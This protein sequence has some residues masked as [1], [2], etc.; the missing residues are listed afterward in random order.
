MFFDSHCHLQDPRIAPFLDAILDRAK[1]AGVHGFLC[2]ASEENDWPNV[3]SVAK[4][5]TA[6]VAAYGL[7]PWYVMG[8]SSQWLDKLETILVDNPAAC[9]GEIG[10]DHCLEKDTFADQES[11]FVD[12]LTLSAKLSRPVSIHCRKAFG[13]MMEILKRHF[14][15][16]TS[17]AIHSYSG[18]P[19]L[20]P[21][22]TK[23]GISVSFSGS[24]TFPNS[25]RAQASA[26][27][28]SAEK[29]L[30]ETDSPDIKP[31]ACD[32]QFNEPAH[33]VAVSRKLAEIRNVPIEEIE[34]TTWENAKTL[35]RHPV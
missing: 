16:C 22:F 15:S 19:D 27:L 14:P 30:L 10:L 29:L 3:A 20:V 13:R 12:Q 23:M 17:G 35:F 9:I 34:T 11:V 6:V 24:L 7:H 28:V 1:K 18:A 8:R 4:H 2:C 21:L 32:T 31:F 26:A 33:I 25:K 5:H